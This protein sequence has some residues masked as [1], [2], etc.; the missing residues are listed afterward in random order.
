MMYF[1]WSQSNSEE[2]RYSQ[3]HVVTTVLHGMLQRHISVAL[4][5]TFMCPYFSIESRKVLRPFKVLFIALL[6]CFTAIHRSREALNG[7]CRLL[8]S[9]NRCTSF[10]L[11]VS[12]WNGVLSKKHGEFYSSKTGDRRSGGAPSEQTNFAD[13]SQNYKKACCPH[14]RTSQ[15]SFGF[16]SWSDRKRFVWSNCILH[17]TRI[18]L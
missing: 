3:W 13:P 17:C 18:S 16:A 14:F 8:F 2:N 4:C 7:G 11:H 1:D 5:A 6:K 9:V 15:V 10:V 12:V